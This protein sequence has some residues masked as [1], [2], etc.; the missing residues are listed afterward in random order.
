MAE[1]LSAKR[2][3]GVNWRVL[4]ALGGREHEL[5]FPAEPSSTEIDAAVEA[6]TYRLFADAERDM[7]GDV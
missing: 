3:I 6:L 5:W 1:V 2:C 4:V 7:G